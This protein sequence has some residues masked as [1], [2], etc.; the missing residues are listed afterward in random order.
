MIFL[1]QDRALLHVNLIIDVI[2]SVL[3]YNSSSGYIHLPTHL[4]LTTMLRDPAHGIN[5][6]LPFS[7]G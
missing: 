3:G 2:H 5:N 1:C 7:L 4:R 6:L